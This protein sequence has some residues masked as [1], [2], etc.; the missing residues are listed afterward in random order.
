MSEGGGVGDEGE[1]VW[2][3]GCEAVDEVD[4]LE[5]VV[6]VFVIGRWGAFVA[7]GVAVSLA[8][9]RNAVRWTTM[10]HRRSRIDPVRG[11]FLDGESRPGRAIRSGRRNCSG[12]CGC[13]SSCG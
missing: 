4:L 13:C 9:Y 10:R 8:F 3:E 6:D 1:V 12:I 7:G 2:V 5:G 11:L